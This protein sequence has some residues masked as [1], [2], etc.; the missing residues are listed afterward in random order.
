MNQLK[1]KMRS[2]MVNGALVLLLLFMV[3]TAVP[4][5][6]TG[7]WHWANP[8]FVPQLK[9]IK[10]IKKT[11]INLT[12]WTTLEQKTDVDI[13]GHKWS[14]QIIEK[15]NQEPVIL[16]F[17]TQNDYK[18]QPGIEWVDINGFEK[19]KTDSQQKLEIILDPQP[20]I[21][22]KIQLK[23]RFFRAWNPQQTYAVCQWYAFPKGGHSSNNYWFW[24]D[25]FAQLKRQRVPW[26]AVSIIIP[27]EPLGEI[28]TVQPLVE[29]LV[30]MVQ[31]TLIQDFLSMDN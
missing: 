15:E 10:T 16:L 13:G 5:Y 28:K 30:K 19:W 12:G 17:R 4:G 21:P 1:L 22:E 14:V 25:Q 8:P 18:D 11:G 3:I 26:I 29:S 27:I 24:L 31:T 9:Q 23:T 2:R 6:L 20:N 7:K